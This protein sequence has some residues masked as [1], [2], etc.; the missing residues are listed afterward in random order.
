MDAPSINMP[1][2]PA[3]RATNWA[4]VLRVGV[5]LAIICALVGYAL[6]VTYESVIQGGVVRAGDYYQVELKQMSNFDMD[7][8]N[9][10]LADVPQRFRDLDGK[11]VLLDGEV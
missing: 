11:K 2:A 7:Q 6:K 9:G 1:A 5:V 10:T 8:Q 4:V 3:P